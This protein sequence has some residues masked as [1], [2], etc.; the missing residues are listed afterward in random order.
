MTDIGPHGPQLWEEP[1]E[2]PDDFVDFPPPPA[3][4]IRARPDAWTVVLGVLGGALLG[5]GVTL[6]ILGFTGVFEEPP[7]PTHPPPP[8]LTVP[9]PTTAPAVIADTG[10][11]TEEVAM[12]AIPSIIAVETTSA[13]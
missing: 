11:A 13:R 5:T 9:P 8:S 12:R 6:A 1:E 2:S 3:A 7:T 4:P 10:N